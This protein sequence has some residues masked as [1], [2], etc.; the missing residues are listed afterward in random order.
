MT[1][2]SRAQALQTAFERWVAA[3]PGQGPR[4]G[5]GAL[6]DTSAQLYRDMW[7][8]F[9]RFLLTRRVP[10]DPRLRVPD[11]SGLSHLRKQDL[12]AFLEAAQH[13]TPS[14]EGWTGRYAWRMLHLIDRVVRFHSLQSQ[15]RDGPNTAAGDLL[16]EASFRFANASHLDREP[17]ALDDREVQG[18]RRHIES[19]VARARDDEHGR[20]WRIARDAAMVTLMLGSGLAPGDVQTLPLDGLDLT[21]DLAAGRVR[22]AADGLSP[23]HEAPVAGWAAPAVALWMNLHTRRGIASRWAFPS[24]LNGAPMSRMSVHRRIVGLMADAGIDGGVPFRLRHT[25]AVTQLAAGREPAT[26]GQWMGLVENKAVQRYI[27]LARARRTP[28]T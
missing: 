23:E 24:T 4:A 12:M 20:H 28:V 7:A 11:A 27:E 9:S 26:V 25:F 6:A 22:V 19:I 13:L 14:P 3:R 8:V 5:N 18:L 16:R 10:A 1:P 2:S 21:G 17:A 15:A